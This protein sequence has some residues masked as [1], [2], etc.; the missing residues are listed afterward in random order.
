VASE[1]F[2]D[3]DLNVRVP[4]RCTPNLLGDVFGGVA[5]GPEEKGM[6]DDLGCALFH[7]GVDPLGDIGLCDFQMCDFDDRFGC[8]LADLLRD[9]VEQRVG[10]VAATAVVDKQDC[11]LHR[12]LAARPNACSR[13]AQR[14]SACSIPTESRTVASVIPLLRFTSG[15]KA[16]WLIVHG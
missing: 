13:S 6:Y 4:T 2:A 12:A 16:P 10:F 14:S 5:A 15:A 11:A 3:S 7:A 1:G 9:S 8:A